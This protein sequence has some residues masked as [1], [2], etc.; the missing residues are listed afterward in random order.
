MTRTA[1]V[2]GLFVAL[3]ACTGSPGDGANQGGES[4]KVEEVKTVADGFSD[5]GA[6]AL[7]RISASLQDPSVATK[8]RTCV[9]Q[10]KGETLV[11]TDLRYRK[12]GSNWTFDSAK[13]RHASAAQSQDAT[14]Q[15]CIDDAARGT[16]FSVDS[17]QE[18]ETAA[19]EFIV[20]LRWPVPLPAE[21]A[22]VSNDA[23][24]RMISTGGTGI[25]MEGCSTCKLKTDGTGGYQCVALKSGNEGDC[26]IMGPNQCATTPK[27]CVTGFF[28]GTRGVVMF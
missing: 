5:D 15:T 2:I 18:L 7:Q 26:D 23:I 12:S 27:A 19:A 10:M 8:L 16:S 20:K 13:V 9:S 17:N 6:A 4:T 25:T 11:A 21:G 28:G 3:T 14:A 22:E 1:I 24:A